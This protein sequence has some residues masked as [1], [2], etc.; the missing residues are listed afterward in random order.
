MDMLAC[1][2]DRP[3][4]E[5]ELIIMG[6]GASEA[7]TWWPRSYTLIESKKKLGNLA[8]PHTGSFLILDYASAKKLEPVMGN[9]ELLPLKCDFGG[10]W[11]VNVIDVLDCVN[12]EQSEYTALSGGD[13]PPLFAGCT[14]LVFIR[15]AV[16]DHHLFKIVNQRG[17]LYADD[18]FVEA[19]KKNKI[20]GF[21]FIPVWEG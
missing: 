9:A 20:T 15:D 13:W 8:N 6:T 19:V 7:D 18:V 3:G 16:Q 14:K 2:K 1:M 12:Y 21:K 17:Y 5:W 10:Y 11:C 4:P